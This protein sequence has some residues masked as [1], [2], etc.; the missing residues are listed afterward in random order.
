MKKKVLTGIAFGAAAA[1]LYG[2][3]THADTEVWDY[4][5]NHEHDSK[6]NKVMNVIGIVWKN[7]A[8]YGLT[9]VIFDK[10]I[11]KINTTND[12]KK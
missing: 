6:L 8:A 2:T 1:A 7:G 4:I 10:L 9:A 11:T 5:E 12:S 3:I